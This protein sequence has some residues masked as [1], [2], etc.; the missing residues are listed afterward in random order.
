MRGTD[1]SEDVATLYG[2]IGY[3]QMHCDYI[4]NAVKWEDSKRQLSDVGEVKESVL[5]VADVYQITIPA[6]QFTE[7]ELAY[8]IGHLYRPDLFEINIGKETKREKAPTPS[9]SLPLTHTHAH[10]L[11]FSALSIM[12]FERASK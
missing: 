6:E 9:F 8:L 1:S 4:R 2:D 12:S 11:L 10:I 7:Y 5:G 3:L